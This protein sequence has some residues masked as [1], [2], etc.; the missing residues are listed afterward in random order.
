MI[1]TEKQI[2][3]KDGRTAALKSPCVEDA[4]M[5]FI[6]AWETNLSISEEWNIS[7]E[8]RRG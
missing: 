2:K 4:K 5:L 7:V 3:L 8:G 6:K 1:F